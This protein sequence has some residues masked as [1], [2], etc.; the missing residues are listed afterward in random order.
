MVEGRPVISVKYCLPVPVFYFWRK[1]LLTLQRG[2]SAIAEHLVFLYLMSVSEENNFKL[3]RNKAF[4][5]DSS[6]QAIDELCSSF[7]RVSFL[8][9]K[10]VQSTVVFAVA[11]VERLILRRSADRSTRQAPV[12]RQ[13]TEEARSAVDGRVTSERSWVSGVVVNNDDNQNTTQLCPRTTQQHYKFI[14]I[15]LRSRPL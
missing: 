4:L 6:S 5:C 3:F 2:L 11:L 9:C 14:T 8:T 10:S 7:P 1:L 15:M 13:M 12:H